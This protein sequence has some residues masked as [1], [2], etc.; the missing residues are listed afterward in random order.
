MDAKS[1]KKFPTYNP[2][3]EEIIAEVHEA[4]EEDVNL[5]VDAACNAFARGSEW[6]SLD[7]TARG[8][9]IH[10]FA[11]LLRRDINKLAVIYISVTFLSSFN[12]I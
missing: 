7:E 3:T 5:A 12:S 10:K 2:A 1:G 8:E 9:L 6:R 4:C 11:Q